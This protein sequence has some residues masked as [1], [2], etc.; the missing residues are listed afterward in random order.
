MLVATILR[1]SLADRKVRRG[2][3]KTMSSSTCY[4][5]EAM[6]KGV[7]FSSIFLFELQLHVIESPLQQDAISDT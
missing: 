2:N 6:L 5:S 4:F 1:T 3:S 7:Y